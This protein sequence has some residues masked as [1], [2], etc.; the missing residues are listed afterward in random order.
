[1]NPQSVAEL[2]KEAAQDAMPRIADYLEKRVG[3]TDLY[4]MSE[5]EVLNLILTIVSEFKQ[6]LDRLTDAPF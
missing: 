1:M 2:R 3:K 4:A 5:D 6:S